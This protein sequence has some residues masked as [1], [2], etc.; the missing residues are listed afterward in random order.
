MP[1]ATREQRGS[2]GRRRAMSDDGASGLAQDVER[3]LAHGQRPIRRPPGVA[4]RRVARGAAAVVS[5]A[6]KGFAASACSPGRRQ[7]RRVS[8]A[9]PPRRRARGEGAPASG[10]RTR[11]PARGRA[12]GRRGSAAGADR[13]RRASDGWRALPIGGAAAARGGAPDSADKFERALA[14]ARWRARARRC[15][16]RRA[17]RRAAARRDFLADYARASARVVLEGAV[18]RRLRRGRASADF[19]RRARR[20]GGGR[21]SRRPRA[22]DGAAAHQTSCSRRDR[23]RAAT[24]ATAADAAL[25]TSAPLR[26]TLRRSRRAPSAATRRRLPRGRGAPA[27]SAAPTARPRRRRRGCAARGRR[28]RGRWKAKPQGRSSGPRARGGDARLRPRTS[29]LGDCRGAR[30]IKRKVPA[31]RA[32]RAAATH[33]APV[34]RPARA[35]ARAPALSR[36]RAEGARG[37]HGAATRTGG[38]PPRARRSGVVA[39]WSGPAIGPKLAPL[40]PAQ[41]RARRARAKRWALMSRTSWIRR[42]RRSSRWRARPRRRNG[43]ARRRRPTSRSRRC[44]RRPARMRARRASRS[45]GIWTSPQVERDHRRRVRALAEARPTP[46]AARSQEER[47]GP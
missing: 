11:K 6:H 34:R 17:R 42:R 23:L 28:R 33:G 12:R 31:R 1:P 18:R 16:S 21:P 39:R 37:G 10:L 36:H 30:A 4:A 20:P 15:P 26:F 22:A 2:A 29:G 8:A 45:R 38:R 32:P 35:R 24:A 13:G 46:P 27:Q 43:F 40:A 41:W 14:R 3:V 47:S 25:R 9:V 44:S 5:L 19:G 7:C